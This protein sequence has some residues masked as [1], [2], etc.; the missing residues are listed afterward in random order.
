MIAERTKKV[1]PSPT[2]AVD[3]KAK[4][5]KAKGFDVVN[6]GVGEPDFDTP[7]HV[8]EAAIKAI[9]D[10]FTKYTPVGGIDELKEAIID[11][12]ERD[13][14]LKYG[15]ENILVSCGAK[16][17]LYNIAQALFGPGDEVMIPSP[18]WVSYPDQV[19][20]NDAQP[21]I[22]ETYEE[23]NF[24]LQPEVL[25]NKITPKTKALIL[26]S[27]SN[28]TG[29]IYSKKVLEKVAEIALK[30]NIY[31][32][33][34][35]IYEKLIYDDEKHISIASLGEEIKEKTIVV[36]GLSKSH[37]MTG[38]RIGYA[39][40]PVEIIKTMTKIQSQSTSNPT[41]IAQKAAVAAL[42]GPQDCVEKM[43]QEFERRRNYLVAGLNSIGGI[44]CKMP[45]GAFYAFPNISKVLGKKVSN[46]QINSSMDLSIYLLEQAKVALVPGSAFGAEGYIRISYATSMENLSKGIERI[47]KALEELK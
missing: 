11:K 35:E 3:S 9:R 41:S 8:K 30:H 1:K 33:S 38:W 28:P 46:N 26:N 29:F 6:F 16:H 21:V 42:S 37:A 4:E 15:K 18:Y 43:R 13:N 10:G 40:G 39:A 19:L 45:K 5:L 17:S 25:E 12:L 20:I 14:G 7:E 27:P 36:N 23:D 2:L 47:R 24:M 44:S 31:I 34:D 32:I 22:V